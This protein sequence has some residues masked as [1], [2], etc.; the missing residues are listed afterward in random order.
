VA[1]G[2]AGAGGAGGG[3]AIL[4]RLG[5]IVT[6][7]AGTFMVTVTGCGFVVCVTSRCDGT[8]T[9]LWTPVLKT[10]PHGRPMFPACTVTGSEDFS[11]PEV[12]ETVVVPWL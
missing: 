6:T 8:V 5:W 7:L 1:T 11:S 3:G 12:T 2:G 4:G 10:V 9:I